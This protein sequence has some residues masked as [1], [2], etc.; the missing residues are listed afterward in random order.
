MISV[1]G[2]ELLVNLQVRNTP[3]VFEVASHKGQVVIDGSCGNEQIRLVNKLA[4][5]SKLTSHACILLGN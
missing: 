1:V 3:K 2:R 4:F 5:S